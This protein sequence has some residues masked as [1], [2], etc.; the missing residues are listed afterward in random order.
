M[1]HLKIGYSDALM[2]PT[3]ERRFYLGMLIKNKQEEEE[4]VEKMKSDSNGKGTK[5]TRISGENLKNRLKNGNIP[6]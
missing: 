5:K 4:R 6:T 3:G 2:M 1:Q